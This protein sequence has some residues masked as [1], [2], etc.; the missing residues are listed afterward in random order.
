MNKSTKRSF[1]ECSPLVGTFV[2][3]LSEQGSE[4]ITTSE[5]FAMHKYKT[6]SLE[7]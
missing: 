5:P 1:Q 2:F 3:F 6:W 4:V 7:N